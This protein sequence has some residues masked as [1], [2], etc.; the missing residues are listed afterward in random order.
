MW[1]MTY[2]FLL[3][4]LAA[5]IGHGGSPA[6]GPLF[7]VWVGLYQQG[8]PGVTPT[9]VLGNIIEA[10]YDGYSRQQAMWFPPFVSSAGPAQLA[11]QDLFYAP[12]DSN[13]PNMIAGAFLASA[14]YGGV[15][16]GG[17]PTPRGP[18]PMT[19]VQSAIKLQPQFQLTPGQVYGSPA[20]VS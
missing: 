14:F 3:E 13:V 18:I 4:L 5:A 9:S 7:G 8:T 6:A 1:Q 11:A 19:G 16:L 20:W 2:A 15:L 17:A 10:N 12:I